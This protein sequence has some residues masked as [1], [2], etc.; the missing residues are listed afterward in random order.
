MLLNC[1]SLR[2]SINIGPNLISNVSRV[3]HET[4]HKYLTRNILTSF[5]FS[6]VDDNH[7]A[8]TLASLRTKKLLWTW[9]HI[10]EITK[11]YIPG[12]TEASHYGDKPVSNYRNI[13]W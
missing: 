4:H 7:I 13:S 3:S 1:R 8:K 9:R 11:I 2:C 5:N 12:S 6:L 10:D